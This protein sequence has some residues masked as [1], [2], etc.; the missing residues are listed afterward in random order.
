VQLHHLQLNHRCLHHFRYPTC[1][2]LSSSIVSNSTAT[3]FTAAVI[4]HF[5]SSIISDS[6]TNAA[7]TVI[8]TTG[9]SANTLANGSRKVHQLGRIGM[10]PGYFWHCIRIQVYNV[11][12]TIHTFGYL[13]IC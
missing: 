2:Q 8:A 4:K 10:W 6:L 3:V 7:I 9:N 5:T 11:K 1:R 13:H 12:Y